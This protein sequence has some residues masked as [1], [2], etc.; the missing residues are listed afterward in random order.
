MII[1]LRILVIVFEFIWIALALSFFWKDFRGKQVREKFGEPILKSLKFPIFNFKKKVKG[2]NSNPFGLKTFFWINRFESAIS[3][4]V[5]IDILTEL[6]RARKRIRKPNI[7]FHWKAFSDNIFC[8]LLSR[9]FPTGQLPFLTPTLNARSNRTAFWPNFKTR[10]IP[11][12]NSLGSIEL[13]LQ[14]NSPNFGR[15]LRPASSGW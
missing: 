13:T 12:A 8:K 7:S 3:A 15:F 1:I 4:S 14:F 9:C 2:F 10:S 11:P 5:S 6:R